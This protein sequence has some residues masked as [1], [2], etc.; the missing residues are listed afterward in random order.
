V[1]TGQVVALKIQRVD[2]ECPTN[3]YERAFYP[4][5]QGGVGMPTL[6][7]TGV[8]KQWDYLAIDLLGPSLDNLYRQRGKAA[9]DLRSV[10]CIAMQ[11][12]RR[13]VPSIN[14]FENGRCLK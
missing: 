3:R 14:R 2:H 10:C 7:A 6:W 4:A 8:D 9:M 5:L 11:L 13:S 1:Y 12:V